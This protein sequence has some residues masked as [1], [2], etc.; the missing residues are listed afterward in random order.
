MSPSNATSASR[1]RRFPRRLLLLVLAVL[2]LAVWFLHPPVVESL[3]R[4]VLE[5]GADRAGL[6]LEIGTIQCHL[7]RPIV[8]T[9]VR[10]RSRDTGVSRTAAEIDRVVLT[11]NWPWRALLGDRRWIRF[12]AMENLRGVFDVGPLPADTRTDPDPAPA[13]A[14]PAAPASSR[15]PYLPET[16]RISH[17]SF[18]ILVGHQSCV[19]RD[20]SAEFSEDALNA[21][22]AAGA[23]IHVGP[24]H[25]TFGAFKGI[26]A[27]KNG[28]V[29]L[30]D[31]LLRDG[32]QIENFE[33]DL[34]TPGKLALT[35][36]AGLFGGSLRGDLTLGEADAPATVSLWIAGTQL[37]PLVRFLGGGSETRG[38]LSEARLTFRGNPAQ[39]L[40]GQASLRLLADDFRWKERGWESLQVGAS[41]SGRRL[42]VSDFTLRQKE[43]TLSLN[44]DLALMEKWS[45][46]SRAPFLLNVSASIQNL[47]ALAGLFGK[48][49]DEMSGRMSLSGSVSGKPGA[50][51]GFLSAEG[52]QMGFRDRPVE[53][54]R[55][56]VTFVNS[57]ARVTQCEL[58]SGLDYIR[59]KGSVQ[60]Q[61]PHQY[62]GEVQAR[63]EDV[64]AYLGLLR[65]RNILPIRKGIAQIRWQGD[66]TATSHSG[67]F[68]I[69][70][71][72]FV[73]A[74]TPSGLTGRFAGTYSP[75]NIYF[76]GVELEQGPLRFSTRATLASSGVKLQDSVLRARGREIADAD[77]FLPIDPFAFAAGRPLSQ[78]LLADRPLYANVATRGALN[79]RDLLRLAG[80]DLPATGTLRFYLQASGNPAVPVVEGRLEGRGLG[81]DSESGK[82]PPTQLDAAIHVA[83]GQARVTGEWK[84]PGSPTASFAMETPLAYRAE[85]H[86]VSWRNPADTISGRLDI[87]RLDLRL[88]RPLFPHLRGLG[89]ELSA[90]IQAKGTAGRP[91]FEG[92]VLLAN[93]QVTPPSLLPPIDQV[94]A[95]FKV[96]EREIVA[97]KITGR[98]GAGPFTA[99][100]GFLFEQNEKPAAR[101]TFS[102]SGILLA[103]EPGLRLPANIA[104]EAVGNRESGL[105]R[106]SVHFTDAEFS[107]KLEVTPV[108]IPAS[109]RTEPLPPPNFSADLPEFLSA[110]KLNVEV[111]NDGRFS[112]GGTGSLGQIVPDVRLTGTLARPVPVGRITLSDARAYFPFTT[113][114]IPEGSISFLEDAPWV[115][116]LDLRGSARALEYE[117][118]AYAVGP[119]FERRLI[120]RTDPGLPQADI[121][122]LLTS[123]F[124]PDVL[125][126]TKAKLALRPFS[127][128]LQGPERPATPS[129]ERARLWQ[130]LALD[131]TFEGFSLLGPRLS[132]LFR[133]VA[134][135]R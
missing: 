107:K 30:A 5:R 49:F 96:S 1:R 7:A 121:V 112:L 59:G 3:L 14:R 57:E 21:F 26:T 129:Q 130:T 64:A 28:V 99:S 118:Q 131:D 69:A 70:L 114:L 18:A 54:G 51:N 95:A 134:P 23:E 24:L 12:A 92:G 43:N 89:G 50:I 111:K 115:P 80:N 32:I 61:P 124:T 105:V 56:E 102:G 55:L 113:L 98:M 84:I 47:G 109:T 6:Q 8:A 62:S 78:V 15:L 37:E 125:L 9:G 2:A 53:S 66:G 122:K 17:A 40:D 91:L 73:S 81:L 97:E 68:Q 74:F 25:E 82:I 88:L 110:W 135:S 76:S 132:Y 71:D 100:A 90:R 127:R 39:P 33:I 13:P 87:P 106:G 116:Q 85:N 67:A 45:D 93:G 35:T 126:P 103:D 20:F 119:L 63:V 60:L 16:L 123:G 77:V 65:T 10:L 86:G 117:V 19:V 101:L 38:V 104:L 75:Q 31:L 46:L 72:K 79:V 4:Y 41:L 34:A 120:L 42:S 128:Q 58:W 27:W 36:K 48:P 83:D 22:S 133:F 94:Q 52:S 11:L 29:H 108:L 44:G